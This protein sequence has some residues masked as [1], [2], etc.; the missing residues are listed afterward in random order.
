MYVC[1]VIC[2][3]LYETYDVCV[4]DV[5]TGTIPHYVRLLSNNPYFE[6]NGYGRVR[7]RSTS[8][9]LSPSAFTLPCDPGVRS[10]IKPLAGSLP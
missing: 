2:V 5:V 4:Y 10:L 1:T 6:F 8:S 7:R 3:R 9:S